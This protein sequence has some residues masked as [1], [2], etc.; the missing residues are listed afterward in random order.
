MNSEN[1]KTPNA[2]KLKLHLTDRIDL[3][4]GGD[5]VVLSDFSV[6]FTWKSMKSFYRNNRFKISRTSWYEEFELSDGSYFLSDN[7]DFFK[8]IIRKHGKTGR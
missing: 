5:C 6:H 4:R 2:H 3:Q 7:Q 8:Y 1:S